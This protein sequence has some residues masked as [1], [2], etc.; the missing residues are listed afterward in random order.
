MQL[1]VII[2]TYNSPAWLQK[3]LWGYETQT[4]KDFE[5]VI[6]D[7]G[8]TGETRLLI[9]N[10]RKEVFYPVQ[11]IWQPDEG[12][13]KCTILN[14]AIAASKTGYLVISDGDC[15]PRKDFLEVHI[16]RR[17]QGHFLSGGYSKLPMDISQQVTK[18]D[19]FNQR[20][21]D[22]RWLKANGL[23]SSFKNNKF[24]AAGFKAGLLNF[25]T[26]TRASWNGHNSS[27]WKKD[28]YAINGF[29]E[30]MRYGAL[31]RE[32]GERLENNGIKGLQIRYNAVCV[33]LDHA[34]SYKNKEDL[35]KN[36]AIWMK[37]RREKLT[38]IEDGIIKS[39]TPVLQPV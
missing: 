27:A 17:K 25:I 5:M 3:V 14:K 36:K 13:R 6:A 22:I 18:D 32:M 24:T 23:P 20:C 38:W 7:D 33:H 39:A 12:F 26:P 30:Q 15:I 1:S 16:N 19:I 28:I 37:S 4:F 21:F 35:A 10:M 31:D 34:R 9:D 11:H 8:S 2:T 29:N